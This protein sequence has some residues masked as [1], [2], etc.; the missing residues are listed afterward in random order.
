MLSD[1]AAGESGVAIVAA[2]VAVAGVVAAQRLL[3]ATIGVAAGDDE[4]VDWKVPVAAV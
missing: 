2:V 3:V 4:G 1:I